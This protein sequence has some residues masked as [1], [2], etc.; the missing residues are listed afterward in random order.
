M[1]VSIVG[2]FL[3]T[4]KHSIYEFAHIG[5]FYYRTV[6]N[7]INFSEAG[8]SWFLLYSRK[9]PCKISINLKIK[10]IIVYCVIE[11]MVVL[12]NNRTKNGFE[13]LPFDIP[14]KIL[15]RL[16]CENN[17]KNYVLNW[18]LVS[19]IDNCYCVIRYFYV[20]TFLLFNELIYCRKINVSA[21]INFVVLFV[22]GTNWTSIKYEIFWW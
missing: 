13:K 12:F 6:P 15:N 18:T 8:S 19:D 4:F 7:F 5:C 14:L 22:W 9:V 21:F 20:F 3:I 2:D 17:M 10:L 11:W 1:F 16:K